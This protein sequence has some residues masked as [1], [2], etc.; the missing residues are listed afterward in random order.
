M[1]RIFYKKCPVRKCRAVS[2]FCLSAKQISEDEEYICQDCGKET[3]LSKWKESSIEEYNKS[4][5]TIP[6]GYSKGSKIS[7]QK[8]GRGK[9]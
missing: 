8:Y 6:D 1:E 3:K 5:Q 2:G 4:F 9:Y 7:S